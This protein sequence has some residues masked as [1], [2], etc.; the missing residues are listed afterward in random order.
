MFISIRGDE[1]MLRRVPGKGK[2]G[3]EGDR[4]APTNGDWGGSLRRNGADSARMMSTIRRA[5]RSSPTAGAAVPRQPWV[6]EGFR[7]P[8]GTSSMAACFWRNSMTFS[9]ASWS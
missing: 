7:V 2:Q 3:G 4:A 6:G 9:W 1:R 5:G 8:G